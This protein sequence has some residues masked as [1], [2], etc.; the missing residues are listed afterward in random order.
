[1]P[2]SAALAFEGGDNIAARL[3]SWPAE[4]AVKC[5]FSFDAANFPR[6]L[7]L[8]EACIAT[9]HEL[10]LEM[11]PKD[12]PGALKACYAAGLR[13]DWWKLPAP[14]SDA[15]WEDVSSIVQ[16]A[17]PYCRGVILLGMEASEEALERGF[18][19]AARHPVCR[20]FAV[21]RSI[22]MDAARRWFAGR[23]SDAEVVEEVARKYSSLVQIWRKARSECNASVS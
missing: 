19:L 15:A 16:E 14:D 8:Q 11:L 3:R 22:F 9:G 20:G 23:A 2:G 10:L 18:A 12:V 6:L 13:P 7:L 5:L 1:V 21:G 17:D 4:H